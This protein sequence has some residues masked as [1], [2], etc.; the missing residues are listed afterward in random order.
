MYV[1]M[2]ERTYVHKYLRTHVLIIVCVFV[3]GDSTTNVHMYVRFNYCMYLCM[4]VR[5]YI[6]RWARTF[7][8][9]YVCLFVCIYIYIYIYIYII[10]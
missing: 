2:Y 1:C 3:Q 10:Y 8:C 4:N 9:M 6:S 7:V 5:T